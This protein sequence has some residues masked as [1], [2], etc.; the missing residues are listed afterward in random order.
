MPA[1]DITK[2]INVMP[3]TT[4]KV[5]KTLI[6]RVESLY[7]MSTEEMIEVVIRD[8]VTV[9][10]KIFIALLIFYVGRLGIKYF[11]RFLKRWMNRRH[12]EMSLQS[13]MASMIKAVLTIVLIATVV[14][15]LGLNTTSLVA[16]F[17]AGGLA[18]GLAMSGTLQ[19]FA[20]GMI[21]LAFKPFRVNDVVEA[22][23]YI[24]V[25]KDISI[26]NTTLL[27][28]DNKTVLIP[29]GALSSG[30]INNYS[31]QG[32]RRVEWTFGIAYG[33]DYDLVKS[34][35]IKMLNA[36][37]RVHSEPEPFVALSGFADSSVKVVVRA[38]TDSELFWDVFY[39]LNE[40]VYKRFPPIGI[41]LPFPQLDLHIHQSQPKE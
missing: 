7:K 27:T 25:I 4:S 32:K 21:I 13:F 8:A 9:V 41:N 38:W 5:A 14:V 12:V 39:D 11:I 2:L 29:N 33:D 18:F 37:Q 24:G 20:G 30:T 3:D 19:N 35:I 16:L 23:G 31:M 15:F 34:N 1:Q 10:A 28:A 36:D 22:Q 40:Q 6:E 17:G 26:F